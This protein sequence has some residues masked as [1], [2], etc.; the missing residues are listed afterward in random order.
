MKPTRRKR[1]T[2]KGKL[3]DEECGRKKGTDG[4]EKR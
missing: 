1:V 4:R 3:E 2:C